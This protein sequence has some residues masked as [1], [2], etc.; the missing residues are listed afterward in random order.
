M[1]APVF[2]RRSLTW[3]AVTTFSVMVDIVSPVLFYFDS[4]E[5]L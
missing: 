1:G 3:A 5:G 2:S 4:V